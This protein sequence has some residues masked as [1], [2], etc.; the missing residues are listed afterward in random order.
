MFSLKEIHEHSS[1]NR[2]VS[3]NEQ[4]LSNADFS[5]YSSSI[6]DRPRGE[7]VAREERAKNHVLLRHE[8][9][10]C[11]RLAV[12][13]HSLSL[14]QMPRPKRQHSNEYI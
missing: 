1:E 7:Y 11:A 10:P 6:F 5:F 13:S 3:Y 8:Y 14:S 2:F 12:L 9:K 4:W